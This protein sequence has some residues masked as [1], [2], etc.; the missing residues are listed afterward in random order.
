[1]EID[2][3]KMVDILK[4]NI[5]YSGIMVEEKGKDKLFCFFCLPELSDKVIEFAKTLELTP[6]R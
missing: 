4:N 3:N 2:T 6:R 1:M 5:P